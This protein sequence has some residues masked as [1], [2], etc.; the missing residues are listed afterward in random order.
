MKNT[1]LAGI[2]AS[3][4]AGGLLAVNVLDAAAP[5]VRSVI[6][7]ASASVAA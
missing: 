6:E 7:T 3:T 2:V 1:T 4:I 5:D